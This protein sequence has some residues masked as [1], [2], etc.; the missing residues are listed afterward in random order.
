MKAAGQAMYGIYGVGGCGRG[1]LPV[2]DAMLR[3]NAATGPYE[4][5]FIDDD[6]RD[7]TV[8]GRRVLGF[9]GFLREGAAAKAVRILPR[10]R[11]ST[12]GAVEA[13]STSLR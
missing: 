4:L 9:E 11:R 2:A 13:A 12:K 8:N 7:R 6:V 1:V 5:V 10:A 3:A